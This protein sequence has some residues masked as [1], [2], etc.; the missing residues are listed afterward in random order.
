MKFR[1]KKSKV[2]KLTELLTMNLDS[3]EEFNEPVNEFEVN[4]PLTPPD[5][6]PIRRKLTKHSRDVLRMSL[7]HGDILIQQ[8]AE[9]QKYYEVLSFCYVAERSMLPYH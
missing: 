8:G 9:L 7:Q 5:S 6:P 3:D 4:A 1:P 2:E